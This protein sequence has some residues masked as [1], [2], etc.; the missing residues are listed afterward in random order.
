MWSSDRRFRG[1]RN[2]KFAQILTLEKNL[3]I[4]G[5]AN[6]KYGS[7]ILLG[8]INGGILSQ[9][10]GVRNVVKVVHQRFKFPKPKISMGCPIQQ[11]AWCQI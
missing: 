1:V 10:S 3:E 9:E 8:E 6:I 2:P 7:W 4:N 11:E 5:R